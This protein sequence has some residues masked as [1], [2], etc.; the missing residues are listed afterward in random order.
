[1]RIVVGEETNNGG[2]RKANFLMKEL[3]D[4]ERN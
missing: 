3:I 2:G 4:I 1:V